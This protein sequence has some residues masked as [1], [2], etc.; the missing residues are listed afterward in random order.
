M[1]HLFYL[2]GKSASGKDT[3]YQRLRT[4]HP[5][6]RPIVLYT[7]RPK[8]AYEQDGR[9][10]YFIS[11]AQFEQMCSADRWVE[12]RTYHTQKGA[13]TYCT[14]K[15]GLD[16]SESSFLGIGTLESY[17]KIRTFF[18]ADR[19]M[20]IYIDVE[21]GIRL[22]RALERERAQ[23]T[24]NYAEMCR[25]FLSDTQDFSEENL[26]AAGIQKRFAN[27]N[28]EECVSEISAWIAAFSE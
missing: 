19:V 7:T 1:H 13:W 4:A 2:M 23:N 9:E 25:R 28:L 22:Q 14:A 5:A 26:Q 12:T 6:L 20:P 10:Y 16:L 11:Q 18:G 21:D 17:C 27:I 3:V 8:R 24:P 15:D